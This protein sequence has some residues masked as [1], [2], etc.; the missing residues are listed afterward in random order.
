MQASF[1]QTRP[2][3][4]SVTTQATSRYDAQKTA[5]PSRTDTASSS[6]V[7][8]QSPKTARTHF[9]YSGVSDNPEGPAPRNLKRTANQRGASESRGSTRSKPPKQLYEETR[10]VTN[11][12]TQYAE[13]DDEIP[14]VARPKTSPCSSS[15]MPSMGSEGLDEYSR[16]MHERVRQTWGLRKDKIPKRTSAMTNDGVKDLSSHTPRRSS[17]PSK[18]RAMPKDEIDPKSHLKSLGL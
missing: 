7:P 16:A 9:G 12:I 13:S 15:G 11:E 18:R 3:P 8:F 5:N 10:T 2:L 6:T 1:T 17:R 14:A 4:S